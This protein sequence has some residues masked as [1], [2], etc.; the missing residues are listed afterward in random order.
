MKKEWLKK[1]IVALVTVLTFGTVTPSFADEYDVSQE[2]KQKK[3]AEQTEVSMPDVFSQQELET[4][5]DPY[6]PLL[7][8]AQ[9]RAEAKFGPRIQQKI[10]EEFQTLILPFIE[11][12]IRKE[13]S[14]MDASILAISTKQGGKRSEKLF[15]VYDEKTG[16]DVLRFHVRRD[17]P[18]KEGYW[19]NFHYHKADDGFIDHYDLGSIFWDQNTP[20]EWNEN[21][22]Q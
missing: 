5:A 12:V 2:L 10:D 21:R 19:F 20:P 1:S 15:H 7:S 6:E 17:H 13:T 8:I 11:E 16:E 18:P 3:R 14:E 4:E 9:I 22:L